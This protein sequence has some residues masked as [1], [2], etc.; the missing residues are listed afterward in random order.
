MEVRQANE[1]KEIEKGKGRK[2]KGKVLGGGREEATYFLL[3]LTPSPHTP[4]WSASPH[5]SPLT[6]PLPPSPP[7]PFP[8]LIHIFIWTQVALLGRN[9]KWCKT[10]RSSSKDAAAESSACG[11]GPGGAKLSPARRY[12][13]TIFSP[14]RVAQVYPHALRVTH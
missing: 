1:G 4:L 6:P 11:R 3:T 14:H 12:K 13:L 2:G 5:P 9:F 7:V 8:I 10:R